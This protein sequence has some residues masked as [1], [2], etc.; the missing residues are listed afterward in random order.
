MVKRNRKIL[1]VEPGYKSQYP[2]LGLMKISTWHKRQNH[3][4]DFVKEGNGNGQTF[5]HGTDRIGENYDDIYITS[6]FTFQAD[7]VIF[8]ANYFGE[9]YPNANIR[10]GGIL[11]SVLPDYIETNTGIVPHIGLLDDAENCS[12]DYSLFPKI[13]YS[14]TF[15]SRG[16]DRKCS[17]CAVRLHEPCFF[18]KENWTNDID[19]DKSKIIFWDNNWLA[20]PNLYEDIKKIKEID[21]SYDFNQGLDSRYFTKKVAGLLANTKLAPLRF[22]FDN[23]SDEGHIQNA[24]KIAKEAGFKDI[25]VYVL[26]NSNEQSDTPEY[27]YYRIN[28]L[29]KLGA[30]IYPMRYRPIDSVGNVFV[31]PRWDKKILRSIKLI[32]RYYYSRGMIRQ[33]RKAFLD[34]FSK[35]ESTFREKMYE[36]YEYD[37]ECS[38]ERRKKAKEEKKMASPSEVDYHEELQKLERIE[39]DLEKVYLDPNNP[40]LEIPNKDRIGDERIIDPDIQNYYTALLTEMGLNDLTDKIKSHGFIP[41]DRVVV[42]KISENEYVTVEGNRRIASLTK[43]DKDQRNGILNLSESIINS[44]RKF[45]ALEYTGDNPEIAWVIQGFRHTSGIKEWGDYPKAKFLASFKEKTSKSDIEL[46]K[47]FGIRGINKHINSFYAF[48]EASNEEDYGDS[49][50]PDDFGY[51]L[52]VIIPKPELR[53]WVGWDVKKRRY[54]KLDNLKIFL[55]LAKGEDGKPVIKI[56]DSTRDK[57][58]LLLLPENEELFGQLLNGKKT[59]EACVEMLVRKETE[60]SVKDISDIIIS[61]KNSKRIINNLP[62]PEL[63]DANTDD[64]KQQKDEIVE[65]LKQISRFA[66][67]QVENLSRD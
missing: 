52:N 29:N 40:R 4:V 10:I 58:P 66:K 21:K 46:R 24:I 59:F 61:L 1:L 5:G 44:I 35:N 19:Y 30:L 20:S 27:F 15:T 55:K 33:N 11:A 62:I 65:I 39:V 3:I 36:I 18:V 45:E 31:S 51:F 41:V 14:I 32:L 43:I 23:Q 60:L 8:S 6:L 47:I 17:F 28:E 56:S 53:E 64:T 50:E 9:K 34:I 25:R 42:R 16:C 48:E 26:Y 63:L 49:L 7:K 22:A 54:T 57:F 2:P 38:K 67:T 37:K 13:P 12:P